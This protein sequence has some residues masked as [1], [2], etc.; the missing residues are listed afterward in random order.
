M[1]KVIIEASID[2]ENS[3]GHSPEDI[4]NHLEVLKGLKVDKISEPKAIE[5]K[6]VKKAK[7]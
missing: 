1:R 2:G 7:K 5:P 4:K 6:A 3:K